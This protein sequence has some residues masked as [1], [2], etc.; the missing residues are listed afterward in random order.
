MKTTLDLFREWV[1]VMG[2]RWGK[3]NVDGKTVIQDFGPVR[4]VMIG[5]SINVEPM[6]EVD[7][8]YL[9]FYEDVRRFVKTR[10]EEA[11]L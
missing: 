3:L 6:V 4:V 11:R 10:L 7:R 1:E 2:D 9:P 5:R 8:F